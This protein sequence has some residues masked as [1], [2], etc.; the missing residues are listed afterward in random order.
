MIWCTLTTSDLA[1]FAAAFLVLALTAA[2]LAGGSALGASAVGV[3]GLLATGV[4]L[5]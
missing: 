2:F 4:A 1:D 3:A 5:I